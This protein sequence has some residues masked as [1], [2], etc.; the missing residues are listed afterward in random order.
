MT[1][2]KE[3]L[4][5]EI[6]NFYMKSHDFNG[7]PATSLD[8]NDKSV[9]TIIDL[10]Q[11]RK[12]ELHRGDRHPNPHIKAFVVEDKAEQIRKIKRDGIE[13]CLYPTV[14]YL[15]DTVD[16]D[17]NKPFTSMLIRGEPQL[18]FKAFDLSILESYRNDPKYAYETDDVCGSI[19]VS[20]KYY[21]ST[22][23]EDRDKVFLQTFGYCYD[24]NMTRAVAVFLRYLSDLSPE[25]QKV[26]YAKL[27][28]GDFKLHPDYYKTSIIGDFPERVSIF[29]AFLEEQNQ[30]NN[31]SEKIGKPPLFKN[32]YKAYERPRHFGFLIRPT[33]K[34]YHDFV[35][36][37]DKLLSDNI[38]RDFFKGDVKLNEKVTKE[39][40]EEV[41]LSQ[42]RP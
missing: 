31:M 27:L 8:A 9:Q 29:D 2:V 23:M 15:R 1:K 17:N 10:I 20:D 4:L 40:G 12:I 33:R 30:I 18:S 32:N 16:Q 11:E 41:V 25:H 42:D 5:E 6:V 28:D 7:F 14:E 22:E 26:W 38:N 35:H 13:G 3:N 37:L 34:E 21:D 24:D 19:S 39:S 36:L